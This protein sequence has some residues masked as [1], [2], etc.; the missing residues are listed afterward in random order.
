MYNVVDLIQRGTFYTHKLVVNTFSFFTNVLPPLAT[1]CISHFCL[2]ISTC[3]L[4]TLA[5]LFKPDSWFRP[6]LRSGQQSPAVWLNLEEDVRDFTHWQS[7]LEV[8][9][10]G[11]YKSK[12]VISSPKNLSTGCSAW[13]QQLWA[14]GD[15]SMAINQFFSL[16]KGILLWLYVPYMHLTGMVV[17]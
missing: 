3:L 4:F 13:R 6:G 15:K 2:I 14:S 1:H 8:S 17:K 12:Q 11:G 16:I 7:R 9:T 10:H 5:I